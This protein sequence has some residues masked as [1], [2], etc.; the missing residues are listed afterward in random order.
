MTT[1]Q[2]N[3][4][5]EIVRLDGV[6]FNTPNGVAKIYGYGFYVVGKGYLQFNTDVIPY[7]PCGG[8]E[9]LESIVQAGGFLNY[10]N[11]TFV[12]PTK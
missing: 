9:A 7:T 8:K 2:L 10:N 6:Q 3:K 5:L 1:K 12:Q 11:I 4:A